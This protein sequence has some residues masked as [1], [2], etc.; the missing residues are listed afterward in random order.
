M[1][2]VRIRAGALGRGC[3]HADL[4]VSANHGMIVDG[5]VI[6]AAALVNGGS[7][8]FVPV[9]ELPHTFTWHHV[10]TEEHDVILANGAP[11]ETFIDYLGR[12]AFDNHDEYLSLYGAERVIPEM[13]RPRI[14]A[15]RLVP[16]AIRARLG[17]P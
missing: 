12:R 3:P 15:R 2:P 17:L 10:E 14:S 6:D 8:A 13:P 11:A 5:F 16:A 1:E 4:V 7:I 9:E